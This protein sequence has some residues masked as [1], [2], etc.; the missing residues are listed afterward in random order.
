MYGPVHHYH[1]FETP[2]H[3]FSLLQEFSEPDNVGNDC[4]LNHRIT[5]Y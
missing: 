2:S 1:I 3:L 4:L 5:H